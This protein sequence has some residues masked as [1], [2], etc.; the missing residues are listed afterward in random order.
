MYRIKTQFDLAVS[1]RLS[2]HTGDCKNL[3]GHNL[4]VIVCVKSLILDENDM[5]VD[6]KELKE[7]LKFIHNFLDHSLLL[8]KDDEQLKRNIEAYEKTAGSKIHIFPHDPTA[9]KIAEGIFYSLSEYLL[10]NKPMVKVDYV[11]VYENER[12]SVR[13]DGMSSV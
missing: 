6:F 3:H 9:E 4:K 5:V 11:E 13:Y 10:S 2:K 8:N 1:H 12:N 7:G